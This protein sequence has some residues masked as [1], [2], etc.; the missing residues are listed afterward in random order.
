MIPLRGLLEAML[1]VPFLHIMGFGRLWYRPDNAIITIRQ[2]QSAQQA[3]PS[4]SIDNQRRWQPSSMNR[5][6]E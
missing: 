6:L 4:L 2:Q 1:K 5:P 3:T